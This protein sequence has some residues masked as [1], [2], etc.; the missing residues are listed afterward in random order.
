[1]RECVYSVRPNTRK[2]FTTAAAAAGSACLH[3][4]RAPRRRF[5]SI[6]ISCFVAYNMRY[7]RDGGRVTR[8]SNK[9]F[10]HS[11]QCAPDDDI[12]VIY[13]DYRRAIIVEETL[14]R[15]IARSGTAVVVGPKD[16]RIHI[17]FYELQTL[18]GLVHCL[19]LS[20]TTERVPNWSPNCVI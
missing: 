3:T 7:A 16:F 12:V 11:V 6:L 14:L 8:A 15:V 20:Y 17:T 10:Q 19:K 13:C 18:T 5:N 2:R 9:H 1:L 4:A